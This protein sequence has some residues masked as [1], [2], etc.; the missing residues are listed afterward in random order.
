MAKKLKVLYKFI[1]YDGNSK[2]IT[3]R[4]EGRNRRELID[5]LISKNNKVALYRFLEHF[6]ELS[7]DEKKLVESSIGDMS[8]IIFPKR[9]Y[10][11]TTETFYFCSENSESCYWL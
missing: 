4:A 10:N 3:V 5:N 2:N 7:N 6:P 8:N 1:D 9:F 11:T